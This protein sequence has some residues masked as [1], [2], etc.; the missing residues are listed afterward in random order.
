MEQYKKL[1]RKA[2][3][4]L[5]KVQNKINKSGAFE[6]AGQNE[7]R[8]FRDLLSQSDLTYQEKY[9]LKKMMIVRIDNL[10]Y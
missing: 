10:N 3:A 5:T 6:N 7:L 8:Q 2:S 4:L 9:Q 1:D